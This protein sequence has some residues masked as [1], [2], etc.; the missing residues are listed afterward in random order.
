[1]SIQSF[2]IIINL[3]LFINLIYLFKSPVFEEYIAFNI[4]FCHD[5]TIVA[6]IASNLNYCYTTLFRECMEKLFVFTVLG[7][8]LGS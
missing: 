7:H 6:D 2:R 8:I 4:P 1:M 3:L 5:I